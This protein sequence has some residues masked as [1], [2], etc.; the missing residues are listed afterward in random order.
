MRND[1]ELDIQ[2]VISYINW[3]T[4]EEIA[5]KSG[6]KKRAVNKVLKNLEAQGYLVKRGSKYRYDNSDQ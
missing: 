5:K 6:Q 3:Q 4:A 1:D 2:D